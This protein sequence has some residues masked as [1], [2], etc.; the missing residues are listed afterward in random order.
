[1]PRLTAIP[2]L[3]KYGIIIPACNESECIGAVLEE[4]FEF[5]DPEQFVVAV[6]VNASIDA[7]ADLS[8]EAGAIVGETEKRGYG[9]GC[10]A[11][12]E[13]LL[14]LHPEVCVYI[15][16]AGDGASDPKDIP[17]LLREYDKGFSLVLGCRTGLPENYANRFSERRISNWLLGLYCSVLTGR[18]FLDLGPFRVIDRQLF[19]AMNLREWTFG[20]TIEAQIK[21]VRLGAKICEVAVKERPRLCGNQKVSGL[22]ISHSLSVALEIVKA[23]WRARFCG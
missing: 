13:A 15:F 3:K 1:M 7:T 2:V 16:C 10:Q 18:L 20:W 9:Y 8:R 14:A 12:V 22:S 6:G 5:L 21:A 4:F 19:E 17:V 11:G 23:G